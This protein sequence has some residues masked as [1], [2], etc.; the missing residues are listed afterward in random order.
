MAY[1]LLWPFL[2]KRNKR[3]I[4]LVRHLYALSANIFLHSFLLGEN[5]RAH[6]RKCVVIQGKQCDRCLK[7]NLPCVFKFNAKPTVI[8]KPVSISRKNKLMTQMK[9]MEQQLAAMEQQLKGLHVEAKL[10]P[11]KDETEDDARM[12]RNY[13]SMDMEIASESYDIFD[14]SDD[15]DKSLLRT[16]K[17]SDI[18]NSWQLTITGGSSGIN[19]QTSIRN[20]NDINSF[21]S[22]TARYFNAT[23][24]RTPNYHIDRSL[25]MIQ[26]TNKMLQVEHILHSIFQNNKTE[27]GRLAIE[28]PI[29]DDHTRTY[30]K[31]QV[32]SS[33]FGCMGLLTPV[34]S[35]PYYLP[36][37]D[38]NP[39]TMV[40]TALASFITYSQCCHIQYI[41]HPFT[42]ETLAESFRQEAKA[43]LQEVLFD[44]EHNIYTVA[45]LMFL[46]QSAL[47]VLNNS[48]ARLYMNMA[49]RMVLEL[50]PRYAHLLDGVTSDT[51]VTEEIIEAETWR[52]L[53]Y[54]VRYY[55]L[56]LC[57][58]CDERDDYS[59][60][61][62]NVGI[63]Y[64]IVLNI[65]KDIKESR[66]SVEAFY[67]LVRVNDCQMTQRDD[68]LR[69]KLLAGKLDK[70]SVNDLQKLETQLCDFWSS[71][72][73]EFRLSDSPFDYLQ[74]D[75]IQQCSNPFA[76]YINQ[77][78]YSYWIGLET[79]LMQPPS[80]T[81]LKGIN[82]ER[83]DGERALLLVSIITDAMTKIFH[84]LFH[85]VP[86]VVELHW[87]LIVAD[88]LRMLKKSPNLTIRARASRNLNITLD[89]LKRRVP[90]LS[91]DEGAS[92]NEN[93]RFLK[94][95]I[96]SILTPDTTSTSSGS[97]AGSEPDS[98][99][100][101]VEY[102]ANKSSSTTLPAAYFG[103]LQKTVHAYL[104]DDDP[105]SLQ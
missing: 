49:W 68:E 79:R 33:Y 84:V 102:F 100:T 75:R 15:T 34:F 18:T 60:I 31:R 43:L 20:I 59:S 81:D 27:T 48:E 1:G 85:K 2:K 62:F 6:R 51:P 86:C 58:I 101:E 94:N 37:F 99:H 5:C 67:H 53:F 30:M 38:L 47:I 71:M 54:A 97:L 39:N 72:P 92:T 103:E 50:Q 82:M 80:D 104:D 19:F 74:L 44:E 7:M 4:N 77:I 35:K 41:Q 83:Y 8:K 96:P 32:I 10:Q 17:S 70:L 45:T 16:S 52:R 95:F 22:E 69:Y 3:E 26:V 42:R 91:E 73:K 65:E 21:L 87:M 90:K 24:S 14:Q 25:Q 76:L 57:L 63:G 23:L 40:A 11:I 46:A 105:V 13:D 9:A 93:Y 12:S 61:M 55:E 89:V 56:T 78:Y 28:L 64:P 98:T 29:C 88:S 66:D 36:L